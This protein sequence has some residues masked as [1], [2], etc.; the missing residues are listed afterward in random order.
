MTRHDWSNALLL[1]IFVIVI[2]TIPYELAWSRTGDSINPNLWQFSGS[3]F[4]VE[5]GNSYLGKMR[6]GARGEWNFSLFYTTE[7]HA[8][9]PLI[10]LPYIL[11]GQIV[12][13]FI[14]DTDPA[15]T[16]ALIGMFHLMRII[17]DTLLIVVI[18]RFA[19][20]FLSRSRDRLIATVL[21][22]F[23]GGLGWLLSFTGQ[24]QLPADFYIPEGF[25]FLILFGLPH[26]A[27]ARAALLGGLLALM[28]SLPND[29]RRRGE[30]CLA[31]TISQSTISV[32]HTI[33]A[34]NGRA[35]SPPRIME[36]G[37]G[38]EV[39]N[40]SGAISSSPPPAG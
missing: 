25:S 29:H 35:L 10:F 7:A 11:P 31:P 33:P 24:A 14:S 16:P 21:A 34:Q 2:T 8:S 20:A 1:A 15:L 27:L 13:R 30:A 3:L 32:L 4:G 26:L 38:G 23:G 12:G 6:L 28:H 39:S 9:A 19:A 37:F 18:Y 36:R 22:L 17:F 5:D 40:Y